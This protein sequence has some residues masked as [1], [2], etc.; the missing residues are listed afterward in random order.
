MKAR[1]IIAVMM[2]WAAALAAVPAMRADD[3]ARQWPQ[4]HFA[5]G[6][7]VASSVDMTGQ[8]LSTF[9]ISAALGY[10][11]RAVQLVGVGGSM[12]MGVGGSVRSFPVYALVR[13]PFT[14]RPSRCFLE[15]RA[16]WAFTQLADDL[17][18][19]GA[20]GSAGLGINLA[21]ARNFRSHILLSYTYHH[22]TSPYKDVHGVTA[23]IG[24][25]F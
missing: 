10:K 3:S 5:W 23:G 24:I 15:L 17:S 2:L 16:G 11:C 1:V 8:D 13:T 25:N 9:N 12:E 21:M 18:R 7:D 20:Y 14:T 19:D 22:L 6:A 4:Y